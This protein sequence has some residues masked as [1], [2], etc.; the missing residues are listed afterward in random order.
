MIVQRYT[1]QVKPGRTEELVDLMLSHAAA[2]EA[3]GRDF[4][5]FRISTPSLSGQPG[6]RLMFELEF[7]DLAE[8]QAWW[9]EWFALPTSPP[10]L[11]KWN[12]LIERGTDTNE[13]WNL[14]KP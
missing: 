14:H 11:E 9:D 5:A 13:I 10:Y 2:R 7:E 8:F 12:A 4:H 3:E 6:N 1:V